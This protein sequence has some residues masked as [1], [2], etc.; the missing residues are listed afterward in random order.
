MSIYKLEESKL[1]EIKE[2]K[3]DLERDIQRLTEGNLQSVFGLEFISTEYP[4]HSSRIDSLAFDKENNAFVIIEYKKDRNFSVIDQ[5]YSYLALLLNNK[6]DFILE[7]NEKMKNSLKREDV[8]WSQSRVIF[9]SPSFTSYQRGAIDFRD[10]PIEL[11]EV[12]LYDNNTIL[13]NELKPM[14]NSETIKTVSKN[15][16]IAEVSKEVREYTVD[17]HFKADWKPAR[18]TFNALSDRLLALDSRLEES[19]QKHY[20]GYKIGRSN[21]FG[22]DAHKSYINFSITRT[23]P[24]DLKDPLKKAVLRKNSMKFYNQN[25]TDIHI[26]SVEDIDY[27]MT[28]AKQ[29]LE[30]Y[31]NS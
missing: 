1:T 3:I 28:L 5:G 17:D 4:L 29:A 16:T 8:D 12:K 27:A 26:D 10:L 22:V 13:Y 6:A 14:A 19:P 9:V 23:M 7:Y 15:K 24:S 21:I 30:K 20:I 2:K 11:W 25:I 31:Q 18:E